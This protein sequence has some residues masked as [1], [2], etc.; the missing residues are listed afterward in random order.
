MQPNVTTFR[1]KYCSNCFHSMKWI[2][3]KGAVLVLLLNFLAESTRSYLQTRVEDNTILLGVGMCT[4]VVLLPLCG[5]LADVYFGRYKVI[6][7]G[8]L[9]MWAGSLLNAGCVIVN[10]ATTSRIPVYIDYILLI[11]MVAGLCGFRA[12][13]IQFG[14]DQLPD[15]S[16]SEIVSFILW[17]AWT[18]SASSI[19]VYGTSSSCL[20]T[21]LKY[22][23]LA[24]SLVV[25]VN[26]STCMCLNQLLRHWF[27]K[28]P[29]TQDPFKLVLRVIKYTMKNKHPRQRSAFTYHE[30]ELPS[31]IDFGKQK[32]GG[33]F[34]TEQVEDVKTFIRIALVI[35]VGGFAAS[36]TWV[37]NYPQEL[38]V[39]HL[40]GWNFTK[41]TLL[42]C[43]EGTTVINSD[44]IFVAGFV[45]LFEL[46]LQ[47]LFGKCLQ[48]DRI[49]T[50][51]K[52][53]SG[54]IF[55]LLHIIALLAIEAVRQAKTNVTCIFNDKNYGIVN[56]DY[57]VSILNGILA[58]SSFLAMFTASV[59]LICSQSP[60]AM[61]GLLLGFGYGSIGFYTLIHT[62]IIVVFTHLESWG[63]IPLSCGFWYFLV[64]II[65]F[66]AFSIALF[67][68]VKCVYK[69][70]QREDVLLNEQTFATD[71]YEKYIASSS[72]SDES[73]TS[74]H[75][76]N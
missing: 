25:A 30:E 71:Y 16:S 64:L 75:Y 62:L 52:F 73:S 24:T 12:N 65:L 19:I 67:I 74:I 57:R 41:K 69:K 37:L 11:I 10:R 8:L 2:K 54:M 29:P 63:K 47:P 28:E 31:R 35:A 61:K 18:M 7:T 53:A 34:T 6:C 55:C 5:W 49:N 68:I 23:H 32:Y 60:Y 59:K 39:Y 15:A 43:F 36:T 22:L 9:V 45:P 1:R 38:I 70:R 4:V 33:P 20:S 46:V 27:V 51:K 42:A 17:L 72:S 21:H 58:A 44:I 76:S 50:F 26:L 14:I 66:I 48:P 3:S 56:I 40:D 13:I